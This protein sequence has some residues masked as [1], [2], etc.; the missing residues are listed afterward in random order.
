MQPLFLFYALLAGTNTAVC[1]IIEQ[2]AA[3]GS[4]LAASEALPTP[5]PADD[6][7]LNR[8]QASN[9]R[10]PSSTKTCSQQSGSTGQGC[11]ATAHATEL[12]T[13]NS[14]VGT[15]TATTLTQYTGLRKSI[16]VTTTVTRGEPAVE[17]EVALVVV[18]GGV[19]W[20]LL[21]E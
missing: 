11:P 17:T 19:A 10:H 2:V 20:Y 12:V 18:A 7:H 5:S 9:T 6:S 15:F 16:T 21:G 14:A 3:P 8:R 13:S 4:H 1:S